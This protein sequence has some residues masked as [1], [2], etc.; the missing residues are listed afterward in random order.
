MSR[1][2]LQEPFIIDNPYHLVLPY[3]MIYQPKKAPGAFFASP[4]ETGPWTEACSS[5]RR[6]RSR[7][8]LSVHPV[9][10]PTG[11]WPS[12]PT[13]AV[14]PLPSPPHSS[15]C[16]PIS[17]TAP[18]PV[19]GLLFPVVARPRQPPALVPDLD[20][21]AELRRRTGPSLGIGHRAI[22]NGCLSVASSPVAT[23]L[24]PTCHARRHAKRH[25]HLR[26]LRRTC[27]QAVRPTRKPD[28]KPQLEGVRSSAVGTATRVD[29]L[30]CTVPGDSACGADYRGCIVAHQ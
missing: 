25:P 30:R 11:R 29:N 24:P 7:C 15:R 18:P 28:L 26:P 27:P 4:L 14:Y 9:A 20:L 5:R 19:H 12:G 21:A 17:D 1:K 13:V 8:P 3:V 2:R 10:P 6:H 16:L 22:P 23:R